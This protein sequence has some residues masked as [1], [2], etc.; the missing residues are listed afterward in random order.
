MASLA[1]LKELTLNTKK[2]NLFIDFSTSRILRQ[3]S[4]EDFEP[5][6]YGFSAHWTLGQGGLV[7]AARFADA[8]VAA[9][10]KNNRFR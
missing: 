7:Q 1:G 3:S 2:H 5:L 8:H 6:C 9:W 10:Q 4:R